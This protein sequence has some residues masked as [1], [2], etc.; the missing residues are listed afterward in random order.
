VIGR[1][2]GTGGVKKKQDLA[3]YV[4]RFEV[5][6]SNDQPFMFGFRG[7]RVCKAVS[8]CTC[9]EKVGVCSCEQHPCICG[10]QGVFTFPSVNAASTD[11]DILGQ[12][13]SQSCTQSAVYR[14]IFPACFERCRGV[15]P[16]TG[17]RCEGEHLLEYSKLWF[18]GN[19]FFVIMDQKIKVSPT[20]QFGSFVLHLTGVCVKYREHFF[21]YGK[22][23]KKNGEHRWLLY[24][25]LVDRG[26]ASRETGDRP[27]ESGRGF[28]RLAVYTPSVVGIGQTEIDLEAVRKAGANLIE[29]SEYAR[30]V[31]Y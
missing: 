10:R 23:R 7:T 8:N 28:A 2:F 13:N 11:V 25:D 24:N 21:G 4:E 31:L 27:W 20:L 22:Y 26:A 1:F 6:G 30:P 18:V 17:V 16:Q 9:P 12:H 29:D 15:H 19:L 5:A 3:A 14:K